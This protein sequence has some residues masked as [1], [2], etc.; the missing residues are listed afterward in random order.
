[1]V[2]AALL[3]R[4]LLRAYEIGRLKMAVRV[5]WWLLPLAMLCL[6]LSHHRVVTAVVAIVLGV[7]AVFLRWRDRAGIVQVKLGLTVGLVPLGIALLVGQ[8]EVLTERALGCTQIC[9]GFAFVAGLW[10]G[11]RLAQQRARLGPCLVIIT[12]ALATASLGCL[13]LG[14]SGMIGIAIG[15]ALASAIGFSWSRAPA[16]SR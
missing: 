12:I 11:A 14:V 6:V 16:M 4:Q 7:L 5:L 3:N 8:I 9:I 13:D 2:N 1:M 15:L 10:L